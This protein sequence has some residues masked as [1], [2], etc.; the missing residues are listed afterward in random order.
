MKYEELICP[1][2]G[3]ADIKNLGL[4]YNS[5]LI[6]CECCDCEYTSELSNFE[7]EVGDD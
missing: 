6:L 1:E 3:S 2:C 5:A 7:E 4:D